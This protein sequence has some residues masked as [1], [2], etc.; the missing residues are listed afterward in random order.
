MGRRVRIW[1]PRRRALLAARWNE[2]PD[3]QDLTWWAGY[4]DY[5]ARSPFLTGGAEPTHGRP[6][7][8]CDLEWLVRPQNFAK[9]YEGKYHN[10]G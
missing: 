1:D 9:V 7:F 6:P 10:R 8:R 5:V 4:F 2:D 3:R